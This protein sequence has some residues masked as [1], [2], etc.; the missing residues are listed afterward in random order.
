MGI[1][2][3]DLLQSAW[4]WASG[5]HDAGGEA[6]LI[7]ATLPVSRRPARPWL[8]R[9]FAHRGG[10]SAWRHSAPPLKVCYAENLPCRFWPRAPRSVSCLHFPL[11]LAFPSLHRLW[12]GLS[13]ALSSPSFLYF[14]LLRFIFSV[15][16]SLVRHCHSYPYPAFAFPSSLSSPLSPF[17]PSSLKINGNWQTIFHLETDPTNKCMCACVYVWLCVSVCTLT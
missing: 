17:I 2:S 6:P 10:R 8:R 11:F 1:S 14:I 5:L 13:S 3:L 16:L 4:A 15:F 12:H 7:S 9:V